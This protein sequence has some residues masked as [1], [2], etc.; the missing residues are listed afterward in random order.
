[1]VWL[2]LFPL[3][4]RNM[5]KRGWVA[6]REKAHGG[7]ELASVATS[8]LAIVAAPPLSVALWVLAVIVY[9]VM[10]SLILWALAAGRAFQPDHWIL[11]GG[12]AI[13]TLAATQVHV[14]AAVTAVTWAL[15]TAWIPV[16]FCAHLVQIVRRADARRVSAAWWATVFPL[17]MYASATQ[18]TALEMHWQALTTVSL[19]FFWIALAC[20]LVVALSLL[21]HRRACGGPSSGRD[22]SNFGRRP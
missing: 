21:D 1:M 20:W 13:A 5:K 11:M 2:V 16:L 17:G 14:G 22:A 4:A 15:A 12:L 10:T 18:A 8:G 6:L 3:S 9:C 7:W 19:V